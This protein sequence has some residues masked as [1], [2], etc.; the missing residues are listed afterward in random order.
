MVGVQLMP[1]QLLLWVVGVQLLPLLLQIMVG[2]LLLQ[3]QQEVVGVVVF[4][5]CLYHRHLPLM[6]PHW[7]LLEMILLN[8]LLVVRAGM[9][10]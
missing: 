2:V 9:V 7:K 1:L 10:R 4:T 3:L 5:M 8:N 6:Q